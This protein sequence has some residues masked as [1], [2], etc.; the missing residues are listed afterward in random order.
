MKETD[1][2]QELLDECLAYLRY[3]RDINPNH[4]RNMIIKAFE[5]GFK[6]GLLK[7]GDSDE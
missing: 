7:K 1:T 4:V 3:G 6:K 5:S 2:K